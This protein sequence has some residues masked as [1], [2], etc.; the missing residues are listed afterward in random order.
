M[1]PFQPLLVTLRLVGILLALTSVSRWAL[2][3]W[4]LPNANSAPTAVDLMYWGIRLDLQWAGLLTLILTLWAALFAHRLSESIWRVGQ[5]AIGA[6]FAMAVILL[7]VASPSFLSEYGVRPN[8]LFFEYLLYPAEV[9]DM[10][11]TS[12]PL[13]IVLGTLFVIA[14]TTLLS[15]YLWHWASHAKL[16]LFNWKLVLSAPLILVLCFA[17]IRGTTGHRALNPASAAVTSNQILNELPMS[18]LYSASYALYAQHYESSASNSYGHLS[19]EVALQ[20]VRHTMDPRAQFTDSQ[21]SWHCLPEQPNNSP[22]KNFVIILLESHGAEFV[23]ALHG[24]NLSPNLQ[25]WG[26]RGWWFENLYA[27][28]TRSVRGIEAVTTGFLPTPARSVVKLPDAQNNFYTI[29][30]SFNSKEYES[31]FIYGGDA[32]F[33]NM[34]R[35]L[36]NNGFSKVKENKDFPSSIERVTWGVPDELL[37]ADVHEQLLAAEEPQFIFAFSSTNHE[38]YDLPSTEVD[39]EGNPL[40]RTIENAVQYVDRSIDKFFSKASQS[41]YWDNTVFLVVADHNSRVYSNELLPVERFHIPGFFIGGG[42]S[43]KSDSRL[44]SQ[45]DL[46]VTALSLLNVNEPHPMVGQDLNQEDIHERAI[47]QFRNNNGWME[48]DKIAIHRPNMPASFWHWDGKYL[49]DATPNNNLGRTA[50][51]HAQY[52]NW[53]YTNG[54]YKIPK[55]PSVENMCASFIN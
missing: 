30:R 6:S 1:K 23:E 27:T 35:F 37:L 36:T 55:E 50:L 20:E 26:Q 3:V 12:R 22:A 11:I 44:V 34:R 38:P 5:V 2:L 54:G 49:T 43:P 8:R 24:E 40:P 32:N 14:S 42:I 52:G 29:A 51:A 7:E 47:M 16:P 39:T 4:Q 18:G 45:L 41:E 9:F 28:G 33:D 10:L 17:M 15:R 46:P 13:L 25:K 21:T 19:N 31:Q 53:A 48:K